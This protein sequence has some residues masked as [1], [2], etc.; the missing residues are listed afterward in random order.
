MAGGVAVFKDRIWMLGG[1]QKYYFG[2]DNDLKNDVWSSVD[3]VHW[4][5]LTDKAPW[6]PRAYHQVVV[7]AGKLWVLGGGNY[8]PNYQVKNDVWSSSDGVHWELVTEQA[9]WP[10]RIWFSWTS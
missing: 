8:L 3:G 6:S 10:P 1:V 2:D 9:P 4:E 7:H 5:R